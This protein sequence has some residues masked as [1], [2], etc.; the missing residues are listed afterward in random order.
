MKIY[1]RQPL[2]KHHE[3]GSAIVEYPNGAQKKLS[4]NM[5]EM[6][7]ETHPERYR[8]IQTKAAKKPRHP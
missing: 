2:A 3:H 4:R 7:V 5:A 1:K 6:L 8:I